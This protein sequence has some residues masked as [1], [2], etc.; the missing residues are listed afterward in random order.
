MLYSVD[1]KICI[2]NVY[3]FVFSAGGI[4]IDDDGIVRDDFDLL[5]KHGSSTHWTDSGLGGDKQ[6][7]TPSTL[8]Q[9]D[10]QSYPS[11]EDV[12]RNFDES[13]INISDLEASKDDLSFDAEFNDTSDRSRDRLTPKGNRTSLSS[14]SSFDHSLNYDET[15]DEGDQK[16]ESQRQDLFGDEYYRQL[17]DLGV[18]VDED[19]FVHP[20]DSLQE[21]ENLETNYS[22]DYDDD[23]T[24]RD[25]IEV[26]LRHDAGTPMRESMDIELPNK[27]VRQSEEKLFENQG[28]DVFDH[29]NFEANE[30]KRTRPNTASSTRTI[31]SRSFPEISP[32]EALEL[33]T[34]RL[35]SLDHDND[36]LSIPFEQSESQ[37]TD[38]ILDDHDDGLGSDDEIYFAASQENDGDS[39][40]PA[41][42]PAYDNE[43]K[44]SLTP[45][46]RNKKRSGYSSDDDSRSG[47]PQ[48]R[49]QGYDDESDRS[50]SIT[51]QA[52]P[53]NQ[54]HTGYQSNEDKFD[55][56][57]QVTRLDSR[58]KT[59]S[60]SDT[61]RPDS[62]LSELSSAASENRSVRPKMN[63]SQ[64]K[65]PMQQKGNLSHAKSQESF[66]DHETGSFRKLEKG[67]KR[68]LP[69]P[70][71]ADENQA[72][73]IKSKSATNL[74]AH[75]P[76]KPTHMTLSEIRNI[77]IDGP[78]L[79]LHEFDK[80]E[81]KSNAS[82]VPKGELT[83]I[84]KQESS[85]RQQATQLVRQLQFDYDKLLSKYALAELT[86]DQMRLGAKISI[87]ANSPTPSQATSGSLQSAQHLQMLQLAGSQR[88]SITSASPQMPTPNI[89][90]PGK[91]K[92]F[93]RLTLIKQ[94]THTDL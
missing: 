33:Y 67:P 86:I 56:L 57:T 69:K 1:I 41:K 93:P 37:R 34:E 79:E 8:R 82:D 14:R 5:S 36:M 30:G 39:P 44:P 61:F 48:G 22:R 38:Q 71:T 31:S 63:T 40:K 91:C 55:S 78:E 84:L 28:F 15:F 18:L 4:L 2:L 92:T 62:A 51:P 85:K 32:E 27:D 49:S 70:S 23:T 7:S 10:L 16:G 72:L 9:L 64:G 73:K 20:R 65:P 25:E 83:K 12:S 21:F 59:N 88:G 6:S 13:N 87:H 46:R 53:I 94:R 43:N 45:Q 17:Q 58:N 11:F 47:T 75:G 89:F 66:F 24:A 74:N 60:E 35:Q 3:Q 29:H 68:L 19:D 26:L 77:N 54:E 76:V 42:M 52:D 81:P 80:S 50:R 90:F